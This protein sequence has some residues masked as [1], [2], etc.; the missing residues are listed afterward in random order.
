MASLSILTTLLGKTYVDSFWVAALPVE[1]QPLGL[2][3]TSHPLD[4]AHMQFAVGNRIWA[5][6]VSPILDGSLKEP[7][8]GSEPWLGKPELRAEL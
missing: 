3:L 1:L 7:G 8:R 4:R 5:Q 2:H 6:E